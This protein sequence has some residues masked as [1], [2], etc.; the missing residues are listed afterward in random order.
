MH[1]SSQISGLNRRFTFS[2]TNLPQNTFEVARFDGEEALSELYRFE[3]LLVSKNGDID[4]PGLIG[5]DAQFSLNDG[6]EGGQD[7]LYRGL[8]QAFSY[9]YQAG[10]WTFYRAT[11]APKLWKLETYM[12]S[13]IYLD[14]SR[15]QI[16]DT[17][18][19]NA[20]LTRADF[21][22]RLLNNASSAPKL[23]YICQYR[24][25]YFNF[26]SRWAERLGVY[27]W[28]EEVDGNEKALFS[29][30]WTAHKDEAIRLSYQAPGESGDS[31]LKTR[32]FQSLR[33]VA[34]NLPKQLVIRDYSAERASQELK[35]TAQVNSESGIGEVHLFGRKIKNNIEIELRAK[36]QAESLQC[37]ADRYF[38]SSTATGLRCGH[39][40]Q[41]ADHPRHRFN[42]RYLLTSVKHRGSQAGLLLDC[43]KVP[44]EHGGSD[45]Y[46]T[47]FTA[48][49]DNV[50]YRPETKHPWPNLIGT[51]NAFIDA[52]GS[53]KYAELNQYGEYKVQVPFDITHKR[54]NRGSAWIRMATP[55]AGNG[56]GM[57]FPLHKGTEVL[58][59]F[60]NGDPDQPIITGAV[61]NS[62]TPNLVTDENQTQSIIQ[63]AGGNSVE[64]ED[65]DG[66]QGIHLCSPVANSRIHIGAPPPKPIGVGADAVNGEVNEANGDVSAFNAGVN[67]ISIE[68]GAV[69]SEIAFAQVSAFVTSNEKV[70]LKKANIGELIETVKD[71]NETSVN[72]KEI[73]TVLST[74]SY[75]DKKEYVSG[76]CDETYGS[77]KETVVGSSDGTYGS[78][79]EIITGLFSETCGSK[80]ETVNG[81]VV[82]IEQEIKEIKQE[83]KE[84]DAEIS[85][86]NSE[87]IK[88]NEEIKYVNTVAS[89]NYKLLVNH[90]DVAVETL[91]D[92]ITKAEIAIHAGTVMFNP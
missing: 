67:G 42:R 44:A 10:D 83:I 65:L 23:D 55:Y 47:E 87:L 29:D 63:T 31:V 46:T 35:G 14:K 51:I 37:R 12:L 84:I 89:R 43:L 86:K 79:T 13:E 38:G 20:G 53:G 69:L 64:F 17:V 77:K 18:L 40:V 2:C 73:V 57:H 68:C 26:I 80:K 16:F 82:N 21:D 19:E 56:H 25:T 71:R 30:T 45:F 70:T 5:L 85:S 81:K 88:I 60:I 9:E 54:F 39:F 74:E 3:L 32:R 50:Q 76:L 11:L 1:S 75:Q 48:I 33:R 61:H 24:E 78:K 15:P 4:E 36:L 90:C 62:V 28:Y 27:W 6:V 22:V 7:T 49:P 92:R 58:L 91:S 72:K 52:E 34:Q 41:I 8:I 66:K 59:S